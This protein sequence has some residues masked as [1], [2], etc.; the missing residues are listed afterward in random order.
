VVGASAFRSFGSGVVTLLLVAAL[1]G[2]GSSGNSGS[3]TGKTTSGNATALDEWARG[4]CQAVASWQGTV[5]ATSAKMAK[6]KADFASASDAIT[7]E[8]Q[9]LVQSLSGLGSAPAPASTD[10]QDV[11]D[12]LSTNL[13]QQ[14]GAIENALSGRATQS[15]IA[16][17]SSQA[18]TSIARMNADISKTV[19][20]LKALPDKEG[21][22]QSFQRVAACKAVATA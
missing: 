7:S 17:A 13:Q 2:C 4:L 8:N 3:D 12:T 5:K 16:T 19:A 20:Q 15:Q 18:R 21:W 9:K 22:K 6:S 10:A 14:S 11:I 1:S